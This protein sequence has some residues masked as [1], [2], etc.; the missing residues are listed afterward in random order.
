MVVFVLGFLQAC[1][2]LEECGTCEF[3]TE[4]ADGTETIGSPIPSCG[5]DLAD[6]EEQLPRTDAG[7]TT[8]WNCD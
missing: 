8:Y 3:V 6:K 4:Q 7:V 1:D 2:L 5:E